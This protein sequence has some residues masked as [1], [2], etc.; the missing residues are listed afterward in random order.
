MRLLNSALCATVAAAIL[1][2]CA[3][4]L[5]SPSASLP[6]AGSAASRPVSVAD[7]LIPPHGL[8]VLHSL[9]DPD[10]M[11]PKAKKP[12]GGLY[13]SQFEQTELYGFAAVNKA[14]KGP[15]CTVGGIQY[16]NGVGVDGKGNLM[17]PDASSS[18]LRLYKGP[19]MCG[20]SIN[21]I[22]DTYG[23]LSD[24]SSPD[25][26][27]G[28]IALANIFDTSK[29][30]GSISVCN[31]K[32]GC[33]SNLT[34]SA[35]YEA[36]G[37]AMANNGDCW[38]SASGVESGGTSPSIVYFKGCTGA[39]AVAKGIKNKSYGGLDIDNK[40]NLVSVDSNSATVY[41]YSGCNPTCKFVG[42]PFKLHGMSFFGKL[43]SANTQYAMCDLANYDVDV[44]SYSTKG[45]K[46]EYS[47]SKD[48]SESGIPIGI[49][50][51]PRSKQ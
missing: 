18:Y 48:L 46:Y 5:S 20:K 26:V 19:G 40:G 22:A 13:V 16:V 25:S 6:N 4:N 45:L 36:G 14:N 24:V 39:G 29:T 50:Y 28:T 1:G 7:G 32:N 47:F 10:I 9:T 44:Y 33:T 11:P 43:N 51:N 30:P 34:N 3:G 27:T 38:I 23:Q 15:I 2:G 35:I 12:T 31:L 49:A 8:V 42:G 37:V 17:I 21:V 41:I